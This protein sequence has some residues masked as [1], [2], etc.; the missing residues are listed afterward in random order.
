MTAPTNGVEACRHL[1]LASAAPAEVSFVASGSLSLH[2]LSSPEQ[3]MNF[4]VS[5]SKGLAVVTAPDEI[6]LTNASLLRAA[7]QSIVEA[8][9]P[10]VVVDMTATEFC[11]STGLN[12]L[13]RAHKQAQQRGT[14]LRLVVRASAVHRMLTVTGLTA[15]L[16]VHA[17]LAD[18][19]RLD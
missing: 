6:D 9:P 7:L 4:A 5:W 14:Q 15:T 12:V 3:R 19:L 10:V 11:D 2:H 8:S 17:T 16:P 1:G 18:A 13:V